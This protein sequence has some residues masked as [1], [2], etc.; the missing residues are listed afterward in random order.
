MYNI[1]YGVYLLLFWQK[2]AYRYN[3]NYESMD[4]PV[5]KVVDLG[6]QAHLWCRFVPYSH[7][8]CWKFPDTYI[9]AKTWI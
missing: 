8:K 3:I 2:Y 6:L 7:L 9:V 4:S 5:F 1:Q